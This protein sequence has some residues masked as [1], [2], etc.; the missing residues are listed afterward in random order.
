MIHTPNISLVYNQ[1]PETLQS[2]TGR[3]DDRKG[4]G[5]ISMRERQGQADRETDQQQRVE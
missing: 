4:L 5:I 3:E 2:D 1:Q